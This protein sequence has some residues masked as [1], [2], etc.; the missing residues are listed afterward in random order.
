MAAARGTYVDAL[1]AHAGGE[2]VLDRDGPRYPEVDLPA[3]AEQGVDRVLLS[4]EPFPFAAKH[5]AEVRAALGS[6]AP[7][8][9]L[10]DGRLLS[11][12]GV[13]TLDGV[14]YAAGSLGVG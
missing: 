14:A 7:A 13:S 8:I 9:E 3:L 6:E 4:S 11:W 2:N 10:V 1:L 12:H 5:V